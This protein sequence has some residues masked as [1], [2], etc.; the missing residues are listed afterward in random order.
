MTRLSADGAFARAELVMFGGLPPI[1]LKTTS[2]PA[3]RSVTIVPGWMQ[4]A[5]PLSVPPWYALPMEIGP[6]LPF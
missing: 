4:P 3:G 6:R 5:E 2:Q 1:A